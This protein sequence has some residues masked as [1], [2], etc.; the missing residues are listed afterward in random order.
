MCF[1]LYTL[2]L[3]Q[4]QLFYFYITKVESLQIATFVLTNFLC[5]TIFKVFF[6]YTF[7]WSLQW[8]RLLLHTSQ[9][10]PLNSTVFW[11]IRTALHFKK[12]YMVVPSL[13]S[14]LSWSIRFNLFK[15][16]YATLLFLWFFI[17]QSFNISHTFLYHTNSSLIYWWPILKY[18]MISNVYE[19]S[20]L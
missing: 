5:P 8:A 16:P 1:I 2:N 7:L 17:K 13:S 6:S 12:K 18:S 3:S 11:F 14:N 4:Q 15:K 19:P 10:R 20:L 9:L